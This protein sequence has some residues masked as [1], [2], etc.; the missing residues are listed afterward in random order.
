[1]ESQW[2]LESLTMNV[3]CCAY[4]LSEAEY[5]L[6]FLCSSELRVA[7]GVGVLRVGK[8]ENAWMVFSGK[9]LKTE[10]TCE[11]FGTTKESEEIEDAEEPL[12]LCRKWCNARYRPGSV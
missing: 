3:V 7:Q 12:P 11:L 1:M 2:H 8:S 9:D 5:M 6:S 4:L 10:V